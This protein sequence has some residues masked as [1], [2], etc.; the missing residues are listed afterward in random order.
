MT[1]SYSR[2]GY[3][4][5]KKET[6]E[7]V[8]VK[9]NTFVQFMS[10][11]IVPSYAVSPAM[12][13]AQSRVLNMRPIPN[14][15]E[16]P[17][18]KVVLTMEPKTIG[19]FLL[20]VYGAVTT[21][22][23]VPT[24]S[25]VGTF[26]IGETITGGSSGATAVISAISTEGDYLLTGAFTGTF[27]LGETITGGGSGATAVIGATA[28]TV[29]GHQ[30]TAPQSDLPTFTVEFGYD[31]ESV[32][33]TGVRFNG[34]TVNQKDNIIMAEI[35]FFA[36]AEFKHAYVTAIT[37]SGAGAKTI[38]VDQTTG[39]VAADTIK[40]YRP[41]TGYLD[42]SAGGVK[43]HTINAVV[44]ETSFTITN[45]QTSLAV[46]D[47]ITLAPQT[48][49]FSIDSE[50]Y[51]VGGSSLKVANTITAALSASGESVE[52]FELALINEMEA[53][54]A[55][56][57]ANVINRFPANNYAKGLT[58][59]GKIKKVYTD[60]TFL[61]RLRKNRSLGVQVV[62]T[63]NVIGATSKNYT[64]DFRAPNFILDAFNANHSEDALLDQDMPYTLFNS[65]S[66][67]YFHKAL[68]V[69]DV[70]AY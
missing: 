69:N 40:V 24:S 65:L 15:I 33:Y 61:D 17:S 29:Y 8:A 26:T 7:N 44:N 50:F 52:D 42:F 2:N 38:T 60:P 39:L 10:E 23:H 41:G 28:N 48:A 57:G 45:L 36:R 30:F 20:G 3:F 32:R 49:S 46:G 55:A 70:T 18:G 14:A 16:A 47:L 43:T 63:G 13:I 19:H 56:N 66:A 9:P 6:T 64:M 21:G 53:R 54:H 51:W 37:T 62:H 27:T 25:V 31:G 22:R 34:V 12:P 68:L 67:G 1:V 59:T 5:I 58:G 4:A 35:E 11:D